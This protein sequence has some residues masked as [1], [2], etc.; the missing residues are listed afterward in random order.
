VRK[1]SLQ[2]RE[3]PAQFARDSLDRQALETAK[4]DRRSVS[5]RQSV[6]LFVEDGSSLIRTGIEP[7]VHISSA[8]VCDRT[9]TRLRFFT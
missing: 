9:V 6:D 5:H 3:L 1:T 2:A 8:T 4:D 7:I